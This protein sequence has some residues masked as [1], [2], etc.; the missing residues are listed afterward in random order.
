M[1]GQFFARPEGPAPGGADCRSF[2]DLEL[3]MSA[4]AALPLPE[5][6]CLVTGSAGFVGR[7]LVTKLLEAGTTVIAASRTRT[8]IAVGSSG[9]VRN[10]HLIRL[11]ADLRDPLETRRMI[12]DARPTHVFHLAG[13]RESPRSTWAEL[14]DGNVVPTLHLFEA[15]NAAKLQPWTLVAGSSS[16]YGNNAGE[17]LSE[18]AE[19][20]PITLYGVAKATQEL[21]SIR[22]ETAYQFGVVRARMFNLVGP[23][24][25]PSMLISDVARQIA[26]AEVD[27]NADVE[28]GNQGTARDYV[29]VRDAAA[30]LV[31]LAAASAP[32][33]PYNVASGIARTT[34][35]CVHRLVEM[36]RRPIEVRVDESRRRPIDVQRQVG[37]NT[38]LQNTVPWRPSISFET[39]LSDVLADW[40]KRVAL[41]GRACL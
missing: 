28:I 18:S 36:G 39:S 41:V 25:A 30:A 20:R 7:H 16:V 27:L 33:G 21:L 37:D 11:Y 3:D 26:I 40:R 10:P 23:G 12:E 38:K 22:A 17:E 19:I 9:A 14:H 35:D 29:D 1:D 15:L 31:L 32:N 34:R 2:G 13:I 24:Q 8:P 6:R 5:G 4:P